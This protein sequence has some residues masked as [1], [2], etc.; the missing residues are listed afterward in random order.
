MT[1]SISESKPLPQHVV[2]LAEKVIADVRRRGLSLGDRYLT[3]EEVAR[4]L[5]VRKAVANRALAYLAE[6]EIL[7]RKQRSGTFVGPGLGRRVRSAVRNV[8][9]LL[10]SGDP[11]AQ[12]WAFNPFVEGLRRGMPDVNVQFSF[13][14]QTGSVAYVQELL[15]GPQAAGQ[16]AGVVAI[17]CPP[18]VYRYLAKERLPAVVFG[19]PYSSD[20]GLVSVDIDNRQCGRLLTQY[21]IDRGHR[22][23]A[24]LMT[25]V[26]RPGE[27]DLLDG[28][29]DSLSEAGL[30]PH[31]FIERMTRNDSESLR[32]IT[33]QLLTMPDRPTGVVCRPGLYADIVAAVAADLHLAIGR[34]LEIV[35]DHADQTTSKIDLAAYPHVHPQL[36]FTE[37]IASISQL[38]K[39]QLDGEVPESKRVVVPVALREPNPSRRCSD[40]VSGVPVSSKK[41]GEA[42]PAE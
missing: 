11:V 22:R 42:S 41:R 36:S 29:R 31:A 23:I 13:V 20:L 27:N 1:R 3:T 12:D 21:L 15:A 38:L 32:A 35:F 4:L 33:R 39:Q 34:D 2:A 24:L 6:R 9:A 30:P 25:S 5:S 8:Y 26:G 19:T 10:S 17:S 37:I 28:I 7:L 16:F 40:G 18:E 14:P